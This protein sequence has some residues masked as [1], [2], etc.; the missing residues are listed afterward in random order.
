MRGADKK[1]FYSLSPDSHHNV[2]VS[3]PEN[4]IIQVFSNG[5][6]FLRSFGCDENG[7]KNLKSPCCV[8][9]AGQYVYVA[10]DGIRKI[11]MFAT[12]VD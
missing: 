9:V 8:C 11:V 6:E 3:V 1:K 10:D 7:G 5:G 4:S 2:Y 12:E